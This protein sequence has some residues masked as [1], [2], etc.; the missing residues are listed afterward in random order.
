MTIFKIRNAAGLYSTGGMNPRWTKRGKTWVAM[1]HLTA[2]LTLLRQERKRI[3]GAL[4]NPTTAHR[5]Q[6]TLD[7]MRVDKRL[8]P[9][10]LCDVIEFE[11]EETMTPMAIHEGEIHRG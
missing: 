10:V 6:N 3:E 7:I 5:M 2:H 1:N 9:Y 11:L 4:V 8:D